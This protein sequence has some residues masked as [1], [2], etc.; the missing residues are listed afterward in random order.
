M[1]FHNTPNP[2]FQTGFYFYS[3]V[4]PDPLRPATMRSFGL[5]I[6]AVFCKRREYVHILLPIYFL[7]SV[8]TVRFLGGRLRLLPTSVFEVVRRQ[9]LRPTKNCMSYLHPYSCYLF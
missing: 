6:T 7:P 2:V 8:Q 9:V 5:S 3:S 4:L 1:F